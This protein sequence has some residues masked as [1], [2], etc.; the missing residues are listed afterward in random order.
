MRGEAEPCVFCGR[1]TGMCTPS[2]VQKKISSTCPFVVVPKPAV[3][4]RKQENMP[5]ECP[6]PGCSA[7]PWVLNIK[8]HLAQCTPLFTPNTLDLTE[9]VI[10]SRDDAKKK[11]RAKKIPTVMKPK[12]TLKVAQAV[13][14][15][16]TS[17]SEA[18]LGH[19]DWEW[20]LEEDA[21]SAADSSSS[22]SETSASSKDANTSSSSSS[23]SSSSS[24]SGLEVLPKKKAVKAKGTKRPTTTDCHAGC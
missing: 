15:E 24:S 8:N 22:G 21:S 5:R 3:A 10:V 23:A 12:I 1:S 17:Y 4:M 16:A 14:S 7:T 11:E 2:I 13:D 20:K 18:S 19:S 9:W 6:N